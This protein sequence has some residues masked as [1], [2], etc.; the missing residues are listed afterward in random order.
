M[1]L[2]S[3][4]DAFI[5]ISQHLRYN[6]VMNLGRDLSTTNVSNDIQKNIDLY[7]NQAIIDAIKTIPEICG[8]ISEEDSTVVF[9]NSSKK[10]GYVA[11]FDPVD[12]SKNVLS[13][14][15][16]GT[17]YG[18]YEY[19]IEND[20]LLSI[21]ETG[22]CLYGPSTILVRSHATGIVL[23]YEL[24][25]S[26]EFC[27]KRT[28]SLPK[29]NSIYS[30]NMS[31]ELDKDIETLIRQIKTDECTQRWVGAMV[32]DCHQILMRGGVFI[33]PRTKKNPNGKIRL[34]YEAIP[35]AYLFK[36]LGGVEMDINNNSIIDRLEYVK[37]Q[38]NM[39]H[40]ETPII[41]STSYTKEQIK[42][43][44]ELNDIIKC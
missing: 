4:Y 25:P 17:I 22:Y 11:V 18:I 14:L 42:T 24:N 21:K 8:Y 7:A 31:Y 35:F 15:T 16:V 2:D 19:D 29:T 32:A 23:Q 26:N 30:V 36:L 37:L 38:S 33:Y 20:K 28:L 41:L 1:K 34:L 10:H 44:L 9:T 39:I 12:G 3:L 6:D 43:L 5:N 27:F 40:H 13:N